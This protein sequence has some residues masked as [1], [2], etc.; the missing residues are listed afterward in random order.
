MTDQNL[1]FV[2]IGP[3]CFASGDKT[4]ISYEGENFYR[5]CGAYVADHADG[6]RSSCVKRVGHPGNVHENFDGVLHTYTYGDEAHDVN[7]SADASTPQDGFGDAKVGMS[8]QGQKGDTAGL[9]D[10][11]FDKVSIN[12]V[13]QD[14]AAR[15][16]FVKR[17]IAW[18]RAKELVDAA[19]DKFGLKEHKNGPSGFTLGYSTTDSEVDQYL[20][21]IE[22]V[23]NWLLGISD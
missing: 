13:E 11:I 22:T 8:Y 17:H 7:I 10:N 4:V 14:D 5:A 19:V 18:E 1:D 21:H 20:D 2:D 12:G 16:E 6:S 15:D 3:G 9:D 23:A